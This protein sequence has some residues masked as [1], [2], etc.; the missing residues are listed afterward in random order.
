MQRSNVVWKKLNSLLHPCGR[1][2]VLNNL[3]YKGQLLHGASLA[4]AFNHFFINQSNQ[5]SDLH[6][7]A[8]FNCEE[9][10]LP[11]IMG[12]SMF[13]SPTD[14][15]EIFTTINIIKN[16]KSDGPD[17]MQIKPLKYVLDIMCPV[18]T[19]IYSLICSTGIFPKAMQIARVTPVFKHGKRNDLTNY[20]PISILPIFSEGIEKIIHARFLSFF[21]RRNLLHDFQHGFRRCRSTKTA[22]ATQKEVIIEAFSEKKKW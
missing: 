22:L 7:N 13:L 18:I 20:R 21:K 1:V 8:D 10:I 6:D 3:Q 12:Q 15:E 19:H 9:Y 11:N 5:Y 2:V 14:H 16:S 17:G 4:D